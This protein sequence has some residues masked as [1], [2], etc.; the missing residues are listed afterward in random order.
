MKKANVG[1]DRAIVLLNE[2]DFV[3]EKATLAALDA[4]KNE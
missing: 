3:V 4:P 2:T 1:C